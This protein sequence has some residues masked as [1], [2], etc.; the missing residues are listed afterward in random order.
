[1][2]HLLFISFFSSQ[3]TWYKI[4]TW[5]EFK[6]MFSQNEP[7]VNEEEIKSERNLLFPVMPVLESLVAGHLSHSVTIYCTYVGYWLIIFLISFYIYLN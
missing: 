4:K 5:Q 3:C 2:W 6:T 1:M 7:I